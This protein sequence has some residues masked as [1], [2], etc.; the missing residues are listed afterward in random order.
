MSPDNPVH[1]GK[2]VG[3]ECHFFVLIK[4]RVSLKMDGN[5]SHN[6]IYSYQSFS[7]FYL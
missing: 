5:L 1:P 2:E 3:F 7:G 4:S 6:V